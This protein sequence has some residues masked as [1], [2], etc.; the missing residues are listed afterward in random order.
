MHRNAASAFSVSAVE[1]RITTDALSEFPEAVQPLRQVAHGDFAF[2]RNDARAAE[3]DVLRRRFKH[4]RKIK[5]YAHVGRGF[6]VLPFD[7]TLRRNAQ[8]LRRALLRYVP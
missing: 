1:Q 8:Q 7:Y 4:V 6:P 2:V 3:Q 5:Q